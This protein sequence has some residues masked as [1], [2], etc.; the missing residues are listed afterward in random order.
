MRQVSE[1]KPEWLVEIAPHYYQL[2]DVEDFASKKMP[3]GRGRVGMKCA[4]VIYP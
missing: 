2:K 1:I 3:R 4:A